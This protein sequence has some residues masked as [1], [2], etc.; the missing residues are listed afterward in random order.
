MNPAS[1]C[2]GHESL[3]DNHDPSLFSWA[4]AYGEPQHRGRIK[5]YPDDFQVDEVLSFEPEG[6]GS[7]VYL[8]VEKTGLNTEQL[9]EKL[10]QFA[11]V[12]R[13][14]IG[15][16]GMKDR[17]AVTRQ[18]FSVLPKPKSHVDW[19]GIESEQVRLLD[20][21]QHPRKLKI[22]ALKGNRFKLLLRSIEGD[23]SSLESKLRQI[24]V[25]GVPNYFG[26]QR[27]GKDGRNVQRALAFLN[28]EIRIRSRHQRGLMYSVARSWIFNQLL[29]RRVGMNTWNK[30]CPGDVFIL[31]GSRQ[32]FVPDD[33]D[34]TI[35]QRVQDKDI[36]PSGPLAGSGSSPVFGEIADLEQDVFERYSDTVTGLCQAEVENARRPLVMHPEVLQWQWQTPRDLALSFFLPA[37]CYATSLLRELIQEGPQQE[38][39]TWT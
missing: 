4:C 8:R 30:A 24:E 39:P 34:E 36:V 17:Q 37:G 21:R 5:L 31:A 25:S 12:R 2:S 16:A 10:A 22:G 29:S 9:A 1:S 20:V 23:Q 26:L 32:F 11:G 19:Q 33:I 27:F 28:G 3:S 15:Y 18:W 14:D 7:H 35:R 13:S 38:V 6:Q